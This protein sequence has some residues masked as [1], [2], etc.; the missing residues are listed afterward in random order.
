[1]G[2]ARD[3]RLGLC[4]LLDEV[5]PDA[6]TLCAGWTTRDLAAHLVLREHRPDA[7]AGIMG[8]PLASY[9]DRV[10]QRLSA[11]TPYEDLVKAIRNGPPRLS[12]WAIPGMDERANV[13]EY[14]VHHEDVRR[15]A[16]NSEPRGIGPGLSQ[17]LWS[18]LQMARFVLRKV[19]VGIE[20][21]RD[22]GAAGNGDGSGFRMTIRRRTPVVTVTGTPA[23]L[24]M[25]AMGRTSAAHVRLDGTDS[26]VRMLSQAH[27]R[28]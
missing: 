7:G 6:L 22:D 1:M 13:V 4:A 27:W 5:G 25:W 23:E 19:P 9:T 8:G 17:V 3:E 18:R 16:P 14:F 2:Y 24:T 12:L 20:F 10:Q 11:R 21:A 26:A 15:A 28:L